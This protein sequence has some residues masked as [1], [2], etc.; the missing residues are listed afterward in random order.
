MLDSIEPCVKRHLEMVAMPT[1]S[2]EL[3]GVSTQAHW[4]GWHP[5]VTAKKGIKKTLNRFGY[6]IM[7][8]QRS[9]GLVV[10]DREG[11]PLADRENPERGPVNWKDKERR[12]REDGFFEW[13]NMVALNYAVAS[14]IGSYKKIVEIGGGTGVFAYEASTDQARRIICCESDKQAVEYARKHRSRPNVVY[15]SQEIASLQEKFDLVVAIEVIEHIDDFRSFLETCCRLAPSAILTTPN[16]N[17][18]NNY[19]AVSG[20]PTNY[21][22]VREWTAGEFY[23]IL[24]IFYREVDLY[25]MPNL[26]IPSVV[27]INVTSTMTPLVAVCRVP[28][29]HKDF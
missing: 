24:R 5:L 19:R 11:R 27:P 22:H 18:E 3:Q 16:R 20:P 9:P 1:V 23:W 6:D 28:V 14:M 4:E 29:N 2:E 26:Y 21:L 10:S 13:P 12:V 8:L 17:R 7:P 15:M 25:S